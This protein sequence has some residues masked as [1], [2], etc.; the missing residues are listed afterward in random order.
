MKLSKILLYKLFNNFSFSIFELF[1]NSCMILSGINFLLA[2]LSIKFQNIYISLN[3]TSSLKLYLKFFLYLLGMASSM[4][5]KKSPITLLNNG[6]KYFLT[7][8]IVTLLLLSIR[9]AISA[10]FSPKASKLLTA[11]L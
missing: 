5:L 3:I 4:I 1:N 7:N 6:S 2:W 11:F 10:I 9:E 8:P